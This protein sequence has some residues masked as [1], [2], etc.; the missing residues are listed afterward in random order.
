MFII[1]GK[2]TNAVV[3]ATEIEES[4]ISQIHTM[5]NCPVFTNPIKIM[6]D[7]HAG[8]GCVIGF[9]MKM[10]DK[11][12]PNI[13]GVDIGCGMLTSYLGPLF[14][15]DLQAFDDIVRSSIPMG[16]KI[17][18]PSNSHSH[19]NKT[20]RDLFELANKQAHLVK[21]AL[22]TN[23]NIPTYDLTYV[24][25]K[26]EQINVP[27]DRFY[28]SLGTLGG[29]NHFIELNKDNN[30]IYLVVHSGSRNFGLSVCKYWQDVAK[31]KHKAE[32]KQEEQSI[33]VYV[34]ECGHAN[35]IENEISRF[36]KLHPSVTSGFEYLEEEDLFKY[37]CDM[38]F[39]Q[40]Y[41]QM[42]RRLIAEQVLKNSYL[43]AVESFDTIHNY[44]DMS[45]QVIRKGAIRANINDKVLIPLNMRDGSLIC[46]G[47][48]NAEWNYSAPHGAG[49]IMSRSEAKRK[50][51]LKEF[52]DSMVGVYSSTIN[53][54]TID[55]SPM[56]YK[57]GEIIKSLIE[58]TVDII[59]HIQPIYNTKG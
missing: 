55:E 18:S 1:N 13:V 59:S 33:I 35:R 34:K 42:N 4:C 32:L 29:G 30:G 8:K 38:I 25:K 20:V 28:N 54:H 39:A 19:N 7:T 40:C 24:F 15:I 48:S 51:S 23:L 14:K 58:P 52:E 57:N 12:I 27:L 43:E 11:V 17:H 2:Y 41:A 49:R 22:G 10:T 3:Y 46:N 5:V 56:V 53:E 37:L 31:N 45:D 9:T 16:F 21:N 50:I 36:R 6:P 26:C 44:I 47:K